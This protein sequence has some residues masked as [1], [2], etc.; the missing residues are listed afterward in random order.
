MADLSSAVRAQL[1]RQVAHW[2]AATERLQDPEEIAS[3]ASWSYLERYLGVTLRGNLT[4]SVGRLQRQAAILK[5]A[6]EAAQS[7]ADME[8]VQRRLLDF[9]CRYLRTETTLEFFAEAINTRTSP[10]VRAYLRACDSLAHRSMAAVLD[11]LG[12]SA[13]VALV[14]VDKGLGASIL[15]AGLRLWDGMENPVAAIKITRHNLHRPTSLIHETG[16]QVAHI[17]GWN[18]ELAAALDSGLSKAIRRTGRHVGWMG[19][20]NRSGRA[21]VRTHRIRVGSGPARCAGRGRIAGIPACAG[22]PHPTGYVRVLLGVEMCR[23]FYGV[24]PWD[25][26]DSRGAINILLTLYGSL[27]GLFQLSIPLLPRIVDIVLRQPMKAFLG[28][29]ISSLIN[30]ERGKPAPHWRPWSDNWAR[31]FTLSTPALDSDGIRF[32]LLALTGPRLA[33]QPLRSARADSETAGELDV[34]AGRNSTSCVSLELHEEEKKKMPKEESYKGREPDASTRQVA[35]LLTSIFERSETAGD[36]RSSGADHRGCA[37]SAAR[38]PG[39]ERS[40]AA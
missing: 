25:D 5:A 23:Q 19:L 1:A 12:K 7:L 16:H 35:E 2:I 18:D 39:N 40:T 20:G 27:R 9:R 21:C 17:T 22:D 38:V 10:T 8:A 31:R 28:R 4:A 15:K 32:W 33:T 30:P 3:E 13:P 36:A 24:G 26:L 34:H 37:G 14:Y 29:S 11:Q 6:F